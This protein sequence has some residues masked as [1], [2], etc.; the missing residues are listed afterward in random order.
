M[1]PEIN[2]IKT[3]IKEQSKFLGY[4]QNEVINDNEFFDMENLSGDLY[5]AVS[6]RKPRGEYKK[7]NMANGLFGKDVLCW[8]DGTEFYYNG[9]RK[10]TVLDGK[11][12][13][14]AFGSYILI[15]P[16][17]KYYHSK[18]DI[19]GSMEA[20]YNQTAVVTFSN[21]YY[22]DSM[23]N[24]ANLYIKISGN[25]IGSYF[26]QY[27]A[28][29]IE[30]VIDYNLQ[31]LNKTAVIYKI[32]PD[33]I[34]IIGFDLGGKRYT[35]NSGLKVS[36]IV[37]DLQFVVENDNRL[38]GCSSEKRE[39]YASKLGDPFN[40]SAFE[41]ISTDSYSA[42]IGSG[43]DF[44][45]IASHLGYVLFFKEECIHKVFG[46]KPSNFN[47]STMNCHG[48]EK[49]SEKSVVVLNETLYYKSKNGVMS[50]NGG[51]PEGIYA[52]F[53][54]KRY[55]TGIGGK[56][57]D[58]YYISMKEET[59][60]RVL[61]SY[62]QLTGMWYKE[63]CGDIKD[64]AYCNGMLYYLENNNIKTITG[65]N[66]ENVSWYGEFGATDIG[67]QKGNINKLKISCRLETGVS[68][69]IYLKYDEEPMWEKVYTI[70]SKRREVYD[71]PILLRRCNRVRLKLVGT[72]SMVLY[73]ISK[74]FTDG[75]MY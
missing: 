10:G 48:V 32:E 46:T 58:K 1:L 59:G 36:R 52:A 44:T 60:K 6:V 69:D 21:D 33:Y 17:K 75:G 5:P 19:F 49:G 4:N 45:G 13:M 47:L 27:D 39:I 43:G 24:E 2:S 62:S 56:F 31:N 22:T 57:G 51:M 3:I 30:G 34:L 14:V 11:K 35:Q 74:I 68:F 71:I 9:I 40:W 72:G 63:S 53:G 67:L 55:S 23:L 12:Q 66:S 18:E 73:S 37:P 26:K 54:N 29:K 65:E 20:I 7:L 42:T 16:D 28:V 61:F 25:N 41:G 38:W 70:Y 15:F 50:F 64:M 8:V